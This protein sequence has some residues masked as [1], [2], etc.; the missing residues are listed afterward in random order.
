MAR[1]TFLAVM[2]GAAVF[3]APAQGALT[4]PETLNLDTYEGSSDTHAGAI[5]TAETLSSGA[6]YVAEVR[7]TF[8][9]YAPKLWTGEIPHVVVCGSPLS[10]PE[11]PSPG[12][13]ASTVG[14]DAV[15]VFARP[16]R[17]GCPGG[18]PYEY[19][20][21]EIDTGSGFGHRE[22]TN[23]G[24]GPNPQH[25]YTF[26]LQGEGQVASFRHFDTQLRDNNGVLQIVVR[27]ATQ[28]DCAGNAA[29]LG[30]APFTAESQ[31]PVTGQEQSLGLPPRRQCL[32]RRRFRIR[33]RSYRRNPL[34]AATVRVDRKPVRVLRM[35]IRGR[36]RH[37]AVVDLRG[38]PRRRVFIDITARLKSGRIVK[39]KR[40][41]QTC[42]PFRRGGVPKL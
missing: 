1:R 23:E 22:A 24:S 6:F 34:V 31:S 18:F 26:L 33:I 35:V 12:R 29:C 42:F 9:V 8:S 2:I 25:L 3:A 38:I 4:A 10:A 19:P 20:S 15:F 21:F 13:P 27:P 37:T 5:S 14:Q 39:G 17:G 41:Y 36:L 40:Q 16:W 28:A 30:V 7:G 32:S 11:F